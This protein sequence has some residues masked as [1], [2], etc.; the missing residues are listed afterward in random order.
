MFEVIC[1][2]DEKKNDDSLFSPR[3]FKGIAEVGLVVEELSSAHKLLSERLGVQVYKSTEG[4]KFLALGSDDALLIVVEKGRSWFL[5]EL[6]ASIFPISIS[7]K[8][9]LTHKF[10]IDECEFS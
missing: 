5:T 4:E 9:P 7:L 1:R 6:K 2:V 10:M 3:E 8:S